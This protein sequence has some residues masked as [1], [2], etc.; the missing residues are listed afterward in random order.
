MSKLPFGKKNYQ[1]MVI[2]LVVITLGF[3]FMSIDGEQHGFGFLGLTLAPIVVVAGFI[4]EV[5]AILH[6]P[7]EN[8]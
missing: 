2:G 3:I 8:K 7:K 4:I 1:W 5:F 6:S